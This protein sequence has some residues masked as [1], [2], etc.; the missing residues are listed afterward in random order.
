MSVLSKS[1]S[2]KKEDRMKKANLVWLFIFIFLAMPLASALIEKKFP[3]GRTVDIKLPCFNNNSY[4]S[5][6]AVCN[7]TLSYPDGRKLFDDAPM[8]NQIS[9]HNIS[10]QQANNT[11]FGFYEGWYFCFD[12]SGDLE[13]RGKENLRFE[14]TGDGLGFNVFPTQFIVLAL[15]V[16]GIVAGKWKRELNMFKIIGAMV[17]VI[18]G[19]I[20]LYPGY[21]FL[22]HSNLVG[23]A[24][25]FGSI[26]V[27]FYFMID[28]AFTRRKESERKEYYEVEDGRYYEND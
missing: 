25:G 2:K 11:D 21:A 6:S 16:L 23:Q 3:V 9:F 28:D 7:I 1:L 22:N 27:G 14:F 12:D 19:V 10:I 24:I 8:T 17:V 13:G 15:G 20:T 26:G 4:C 18:M 5:S